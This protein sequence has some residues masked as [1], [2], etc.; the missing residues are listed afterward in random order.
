MFNSDAVTS[1]TFRE[2][3]DACWQARKI[4]ELLPELPQGMRPRHI[5]VLDAVHVIGQSGPARVGEISEFLHIS[6]PSVTKM[7]NELSDMGYLGKDGSKTDGRG[8][9]VTLTPSGKRCR[10]TLVE[11]YRERICRS[12]TGKVT[13]E[14]CRTTTATIR[15]LLQAVILD[16]TAHNHHES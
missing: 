7:I 12:L 6:T 1:D 15:Q 9:E 5:S 2:L 13:D 14:D 10:S 11:D 16:N 4:T 8:V 3:F